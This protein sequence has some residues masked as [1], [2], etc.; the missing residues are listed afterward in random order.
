VIAIL[1]AGSV[2]L[3][4]YFKDLNK[5]ESAQLIQF[6]GFS[7]IIKIGCIKSLIFIQQF[8]KKNIM[9]AGTSDVG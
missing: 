9:S 5:N 8:R 2:V 4:Y 6:R 1:K 3:F 7:M